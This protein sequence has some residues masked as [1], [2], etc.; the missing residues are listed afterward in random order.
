MARDVSLIQLQFH[1]SYASPHPRNL[2]IL[3]MLKLT[4]LVMGMINV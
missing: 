2:G 1:A 4:Y 3:E